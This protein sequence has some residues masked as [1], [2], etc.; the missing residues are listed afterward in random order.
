M[1]FSIS[2]LIK[3]QTQPCDSAW[4]ESE[5]RGALLRPVDDA[6]QRG[7]M[8][9]RDIDKIWTNMRFAELLKCKILSVMD[10]YPLNDY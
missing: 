7:G 6:R 8:T 3:R 1:I 9:A 4:L 2:S 5:Q 10:V